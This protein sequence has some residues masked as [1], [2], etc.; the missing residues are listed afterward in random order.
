MRDLP[1]PG[2]V[3]HLHEVSTFLLMLEQLA[4]ALSNIALLIRRRGLPRLWLCLSRHLVLNMINSLQH[5]LAL[6][7]LD[8]LRR[9]PLPDVYDVKLAA[10]LDLVQLVDSE[11]VGFDALLNSFLANE[12]LNSRSNELSNVVLANRAAPVTVGGERGLL[13]ETN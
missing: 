3:A 12:G 6:Y 13:W 10:Y 11:A 2:L 7:N 5:R 8:Q 4:D 1:S 9:P